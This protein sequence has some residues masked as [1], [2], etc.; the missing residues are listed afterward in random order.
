MSDKWSGMV[1]EYRSRYRSAGRAVVALLTIG[2]AIGCSASAKVD[3]AARDQCEQDAGVGNC[4]LRNRLWV[5]IGS[6]DGTTSTALTPSTKAPTSAPTTAPTTATSVPVTTVTVP[7]S[8]G[9]RNVLTEPAGLFCRDLK[10]RGYSYSAAMDY[11]RSHG[12]PNQMD[13]DRNGIPCET[14]FPRPDV[15]AYWGVQP[16]SPPTDSVPSG[17]S[18]KDLYT[19]G[20]TYSVAVAYWYYAGVP[21]RMDIDGNG[22]PCETVYPPSIVNSFWYG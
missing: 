7:A 11:W 21:A 18:C 2:A 3:T 13:A 1:T 15:T 8:V 16:I 19:A 9:P 10:V 12:E 22:I 4:V 14:V 5:P 6:R 17:L 20:Y